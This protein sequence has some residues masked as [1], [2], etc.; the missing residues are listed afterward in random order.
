MGYTRYYRVVGKIDPEKFKDYSKD[1]KILCEEI[2]NKWGNGI[3]GWNG[4]GEP[5]FDDNEI[6]FNG[7]GDQSNETFELTT[8]TSGFNFCKTQRNP[9]DKHVLACLI[10]AKEYF[11]DNIEISSDG[12]NDDNQV[13]SLLISLKR[14]RKIKSIL[15]EERM[16]DTI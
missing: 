6:S 1:C 3:A 15:D 4:S 13:N 16:E 10:L 8:N 11:G 14:D 9:Y 5:H 12:D 2:T 7:E